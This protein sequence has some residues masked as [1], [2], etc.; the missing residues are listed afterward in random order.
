MH[1]THTQK[2]EVEVWEIE[3]K[4]KKNDSILPIT[5]LLQKNTENSSVFHQENNIC[6]NFIQV[7]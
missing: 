3:M 5:F 1:P 2:S 6:R 7:K 4:W